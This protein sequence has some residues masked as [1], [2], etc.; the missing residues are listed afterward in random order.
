MKLVSHLNEKSTQVQI[1]GLTLSQLCSNK[2]STRIMVNSTTDIFPR[3]RH[4]TYAGGILV[5][6]KASR[7]S[8]RFL[9]EAVNTSNF[10]ERHSEAEEVGNGSNSLSEAN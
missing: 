9:S 7:L 10:S 1:P 2:P 8:V 4:S 6:C 5:Y 3:L